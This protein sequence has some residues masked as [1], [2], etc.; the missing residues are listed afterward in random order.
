MAHWLRPKRP[1]GPVPFEAK[2]GHRP[3]HTPRLAP[4]ISPS[5]QPPPGLPRQDVSHPA[6]LQRSGHSGG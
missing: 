1:K 4:R 6:I 2:A 5:A 3:Q